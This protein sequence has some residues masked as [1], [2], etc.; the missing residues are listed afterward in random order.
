MARSHQ[1]A[2]AAAPP[3]PLHWQIT[4]A[5]AKTPDSRPLFRVHSHPSP[6]TTTQP[7][8]HSHLPPISCPHPCH[9]RLSRIPGTIVLSSKQIK[10]PKTNERRPQ[11]TQPLSILVQPESYT[12]TRSLTHHSSVITASGHVSEDAIPSQQA[13]RDQSITSSHHSHHPRKQSS[14]CRRSS[15]LHPSLV[16]DSTEEQFL[17]G[18]LR[19]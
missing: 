10:C 2:A 1:P 8:N 9:F 15:H 19:V 18:E 11:D 5:G 13:L 16:L 7:L 6:T 17:A 3:P 14:A 12:P 4:C